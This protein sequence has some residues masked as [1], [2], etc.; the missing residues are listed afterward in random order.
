MLGTG[1]D[2][3]AR[4]IAPRLAE[5]AIWSWFWIYVT[6]AAGGTPNVGTPCRSLLPLVPLALVVI[7]VFRGGNELLGR[8]QVVSV[9]RLA[10]S[11]HGDLGGV[12][13]VIVPEHVEAAA[14]LLDRADQLR[15]L[16]FIFIDDDNGLLPGRAAS[17]DSNFGKNVLRR[18]VENA[19]RGVE[20][21]TVEMI[22]GYRICGVSREEFADWT[23]IGS[24]VVDRDPRNP[25]RI[26]RWYR[27]PD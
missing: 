5:F 17:S 15:F 13:K 16:V 14:A 2:W 21:E 12:M 25:S 23:G 27:F 18:L 9:I 10:P 3:S 6:K 22:L 20:A 11:G 19:L 24:V 1:R 7:A 8:S 26:G 4:G